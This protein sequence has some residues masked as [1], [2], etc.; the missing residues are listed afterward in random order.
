LAGPAGTLEALAADLGRQWPIRL[1]EPEA[2][3]AVW[4][5]AVDFSWA[6][7]AG[8]LCKIPLTLA[9]GPE[10][11]ALVGALPG[12]RGWMGA[13]GNVGFLS[14]PAG[15]DAQ[16]LDARLRS[17][18]WAA[19]VWRGT[20]PLWLGVSPRF[21]IDAAVKRALDPQNRFLALR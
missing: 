8:L 7:P 16:A 9:R 12:A 20:G 10:F 5:T 19:L 11:A 18:R 17:L 1:L 2:G 21:D 6:Y 13:A 3:Q 14:L 4:Q 15:A